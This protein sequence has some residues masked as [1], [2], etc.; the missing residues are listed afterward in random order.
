MEP[1][2][3]HEA[4]VWVSQGGVKVL[5]TGPWLESSSEYSCL[6]DHISV[7]AALIQPGVLRCY[8][9]GN[10][11]REHH[12]APPPIQIAEP[13]WILYLLFGFQLT[14]PGW[15]C[16]R[17]PWAVRSSL[18][19]WC[20]STRRE[21]Y[22][23]CRRLSTTG[24]PLTVRTTVLP[25]WFFFGFTAQTR[26]IKSFCLRLLL[27]HMNAIVIV[28]MLSSLISVSVTT[29]EQH[30]LVQALVLVFLCAHTHIEQCL[31]VPV[32]TK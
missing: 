3:Q 22:L 25:Q 18:P 21:T 5:I 11:S 24:C 20:L 26:N 13:T 9:P 2:L 29:I 17:W 27:H 32:G 12:G 1:Q 30:V 19:R 7:P 31:M 4:S 14:T 15:W 16:S 28:A 6:F 8:C 23:P 10:T